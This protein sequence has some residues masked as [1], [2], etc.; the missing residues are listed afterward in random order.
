MELDKIRFE[1]LE[2]RSL[3]EIVRETFVPLSADYLD[4]LAIGGSIARA[5]TNPHDIDTVVC[6]LPNR[7]RLNPYA[8]VQ[9]FDYVYEQIR[10]SS[11]ARL[12]ELRTGL[13]EGELFIPLPELLM[14]VEDTTYDQIGRAHV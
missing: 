10:R 12:I 14:A 4:H 3:L 5:V 11:H 9:L 6:N 2:G 13:F 7:E 8:L 1:G